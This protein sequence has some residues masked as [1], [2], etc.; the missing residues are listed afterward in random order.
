MTL[1]LPFGPPAVP[2]GTSACGFIRRNDRCRSMHQFQLDCPS[3]G[4]PRHFARQA[5]VER[6]RNNGSTCKKCSNGGQRNPQFGKKL[7][8]ATIA[9]RTATWRANGSNVEQAKSQLQRVTNRTPLHQIWSEKYGVEEADRRLAEFRVKQSASHR[10]T[11]N[12]MFG[13]PSPQGS[14]NGWSGWYRGQYFRSLR[15]LALMVLMDHVGL[16]WRSAE[17]R[18]YAIPYVDPLG[19]PRTYFADFIVEDK[20]LVESKPMRLWGTPLVACKRSA[21]VAFCSER[22]WAYCMYETQPLPYPQMKALHDEGV[23]VWLPRYATL[24]DAWEER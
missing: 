12:S 21:A 23:L 18:E 14:G 7:D 20:V 2:L 9:K 1:Y 24:F 15:E 19:A 10:G 4:R 8:P 22:E 17:T 16:A 13:K 3:C 5:N 11:Q 6:A